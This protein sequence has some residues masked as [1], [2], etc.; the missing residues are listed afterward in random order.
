MSTPSKLGDLRVVRLFALAATLVASLAVAGTA[1]AA[2]LI[3]RNASGVRI[4]ANAKGEAMLTY[5]AHGAVRHVLVW[6][7]INARTPAAGGQQVKLKV[8]YSGGWHLH[9]T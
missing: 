7:A 5:R 9:R 4:A 2:Q 6:G 1:S 3:D 8:D